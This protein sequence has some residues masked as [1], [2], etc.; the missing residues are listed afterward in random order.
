M[1]NLDSTRVKAG[2]FISNIKLYRQARQIKIIEFQ[3]LPRSKKEIEWESLHWKLE[4][5]NMISSA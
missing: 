1:V 5:N 4:G 3:T 2:D